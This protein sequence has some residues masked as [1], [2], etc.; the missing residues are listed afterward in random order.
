LLLINKSEKKS[1]KS[2]RFKKN[3]LLANPNNKK[4]YLRSGSRVNVLA[5]CPPI[6]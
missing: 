2:T 4:P 1:L 3:S 5:I 6:G